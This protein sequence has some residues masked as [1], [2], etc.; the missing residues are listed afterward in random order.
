[1]V[2][3]FFGLTILALFGLTVFFVMF[4][5]AHAD[6]IVST[7]TTSGEVAFLLNC[8]AP[9]TANLT[10]TLNGSLVTS[11]DFSGYTWGLFTSIPAGRY[12]LTLENAGG[13][14]DEA[15]VNT[16]TFNPQFTQQVNDRLGKEIVG[17]AVLLGVGLGAALLGFEGGFLLV[18][19][20][21]MIEAEQGY[22]PS[23][24]VILMI[25]FAATCTGIGLYMIFGGLLK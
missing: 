9:C 8:S 13:V 21:L 14:F 16:G 11:G 22:A 2:K 23:W 20:A 4:D 10:H 17:G 3:V 18:G 12:N 5:V 7:A 6:E 24:T 1:M 25:I 19:L 15:E